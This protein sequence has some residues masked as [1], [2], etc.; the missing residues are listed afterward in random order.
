MGQWMSCWKTL[1]KYKTRAW[2]GQWFCDQDC[3]NIL[4]AWNLSNHLLF[5]DHLVVTSSIGWLS[6]CFIRRHSKWAKENE[7]GD[8]F[9][10]R[11]IKLCWSS[12]YCK[13]NTDIVSEREE[14]Q[15][16]YDR[17]RETGSV[18]AGEQI[19]TSVGVIKILSLG[20]FL[21]GFVNDFL[22]GRAVLLTE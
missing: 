5:L 4:F 18:S 21:Y 11:K 22:V 7:L 9:L 10:L 14:N 20:W 13:L 6:G 3:L 17:Q 19:D 1:R 15:K 2:R 8:L 16:N 12:S